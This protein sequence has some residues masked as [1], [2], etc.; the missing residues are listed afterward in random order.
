MKTYVP[1]MLNIMNAMICLKS[2]VEDFYF[3]ALISIIANYI[4]FVKGL[5]CWYFDIL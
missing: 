2:L 3:T 5:S 1:T 4:L